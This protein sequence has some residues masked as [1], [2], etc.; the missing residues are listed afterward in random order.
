MK[1]GSGTWPRPEEAWLES[2]V[3]HPLSGAGACARAA[4]EGAASAHGLW[5]DAVRDQVQATIEPLEVGALGLRALFG[6]LLGSTWLVPYRFELGRLD[7]ATLIA[8]SPPAGVALVA[9]LPPIPPQTVGDAVAIR[10]DR[11]GL[12]YE[13]RT[14]PGWRAPSGD[15]Q[16][17]WFGGRRRVLL[18]RCGSTATR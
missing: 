2:A 13:P 18:V 14:P 11:E 7:S 5:S 4:M 16:D 1:A 15:E 10:H 8:I 6:F 3:D 12:I 17:R 9:E